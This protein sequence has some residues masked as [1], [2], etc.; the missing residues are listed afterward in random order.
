[1]LTVRLEDPISADR[2]AHGVFS[3][4]VDEPVVVD[5]NVL[6][7]RGAGVVGRVESEHFPAIKGNRCCVR[8]TLNSI[9]ISGKDFPIQTSTLFAH[10]NG[11][12][13]DPASST[14]PDAIRLTVGR[15]LTFRLAQATYVAGDEVSSR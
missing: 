8:L 14:S 7:A 1:L 15:R 6:V 13:A 2:N 3:A 12:N 9:D 10:R 4:V 11:G 5:G